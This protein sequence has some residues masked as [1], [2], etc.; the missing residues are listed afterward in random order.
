MSV[1]GQVLIVGIVVGIIVT[2]QRLKIG[3]HGAELLAWLEHRD[4]PGGNLDRTP[5]PRV[6]GHSRLAVADLERTEAANLDVF[7]ELKGFL[8]GVEKGV[9]DPC[10]VLFR[11]EGAGGSRYLLRYVFDEIGLGHREDWRWAT[12]SR[13]IGRSNID[14]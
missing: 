8:D 4:R 7:L 14:P 1:A 10:A 2:R 6:S 5:G 13:P 11:N 12:A 3:H 9:D